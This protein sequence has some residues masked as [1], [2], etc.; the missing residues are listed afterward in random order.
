MAK[1]WPLQGCKAGGFGHFESRMSAKHKK[2]MAGMVA[3]MLV[4]ALVPLAGDSSLAVL[5]PAARPL[6]RNRPA[7]RK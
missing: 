6:W 1:S 3:R 2:S 4:G 7:V 5:S